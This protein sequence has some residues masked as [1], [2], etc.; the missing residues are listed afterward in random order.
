MLFDVALE[1]TLGTGLGG[2]LD[3]YAEYIDLARFPEP[4][5][6]VALQDFLRAKYARYKF[7][8]IIATSG[9]DLDFATRY[10][11]DLFPG[12]PLVFS[13]GPDPHPG[14]NATGV[15]SE[16][17]LRDTVQI[18]QQPSPS[19]EAVLRFVDEAPQ[20]PLFEKFRARFLASVKARDA[21]SVM[22]WSTPALQAHFQQGLALPKSAFSGPRYE[23]TEWAELEKVLSL[24]GTFT[25]TRGALAGRREF[26]AP[27]T[28]SAFPSP[29]NAIVEKMPGHDANPEG[30][31]WVVLGE[32]VPVVLEPSANAKIVEQLSHNLVLLSGAEAPGNLPVR[33]REVFTPGGRRGWIAA[34][35]LRDPADYH[36]CFA[37]IDGEWRLASFERDRSPS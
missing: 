25:T 8:L 10:R 18:G 35:Q 31:P 24:G 17:N 5:Y 23:D 2:R 30:D 9:A 27:Y 13:S 11:D 32:R 33:W 36:A 1:R 7:D 4:E 14:P 22:G 6:Q 28:Y 37:Q 29:L 12:V 26:C 15:V 20:D 19:Q 16:L 3:F 34:E 21:E